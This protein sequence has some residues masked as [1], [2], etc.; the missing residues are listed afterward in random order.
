MTCTWSRFSRA[1]CRL[2]ALFSAQNIKGCLRKKRYLFRKVPLKGRYLIFRRHLAQKV[3]VFLQAPYLLSHDLRYCYT[4]SVAFFNCVP[5]LVSCHL[6]WHSR[7]ITTVLLHFVFLFSCHISPSSIL[8]ITMVATSNISHNCSS[9]CF[10]SVLKSP[11]Q[12]GARSSVEVLTETRHIMDHV[13][14]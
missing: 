10:A 3:P 14:C 1:Q 9:R 7:S 5:H 11:A 4:C 2:P 13:S 12:M 8:A 6:Y